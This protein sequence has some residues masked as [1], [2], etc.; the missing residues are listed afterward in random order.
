M[1]RQTSQPCILSKSQ[2]LIA[3]V[4]PGT[5]GQVTFLAVEGEVGD[6]HHAGALGDGRSVPGDLSIVAQ[7]HISVH[8]P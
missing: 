1:V 4:G 7:F 3:V 5:E 2:Y 8:W 6:V